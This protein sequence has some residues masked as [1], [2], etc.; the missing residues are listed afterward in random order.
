M[1]KYIR[2][3]KNNTYENVYEVI[4]DYDELYWEV[5]DNSI[6]RY[7]GLIPKCNVIKQSDK[8]EDLIDEFVI[9]Y[10]DKHPFYKKPLVSVHCEIECLL[11][12]HDLNKCDVYGAIWK[13]EEGLIYVAKLNDKG[14]LKLI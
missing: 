12:E 13:Q 1:P 3:G 7:S 10:K 9:D 5:K 4:S 14:E 11:K 8:L 2:T 6:S